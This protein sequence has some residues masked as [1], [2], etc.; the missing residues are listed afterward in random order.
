VGAADVQEA[1]WAGG[2]AGAD[3]HAGQH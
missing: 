2:E 1:G 3:C